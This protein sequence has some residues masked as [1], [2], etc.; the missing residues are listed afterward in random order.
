MSC[1]K[2]EQSTRLRFTISS[3]FPIFENPGHVQGDYGLSDRGGG[4]AD[5]KPSWHNDPAI[6]LKNSIDSGRYGLRQWKALER[7]SRLFSKAL[8][9]SIL[10]W[11]AVMV[12]GLAGEIRAGVVYH[13]DN[14]G[15]DAASG[16]ETAP[17]RTIAEALVR[18]QPGDQIVLRQ[19]VYREVLVAN[20][21]GTENAPIIIANYP[22][23]RA[24]VSALNEVNGEGVKADTGAGIYRISR[25]DN[26]LAGFGPS[27]DGFYQVFIDG[28]MAQEARHPNKQSGD[29]LSAD[30]AALTMDNQY[31]FTGLDTS[32]FSESD[33]VGARFLGNVGQGWAWQTSVV[34]SRS[35]QR[36]Q[37]RPEKSSQ[38]WW[39]NIDVKK[40]SDA[41][42]GYLVGREAFL[43]ADGE[44][45][46][47]EK[48]LYIKVSGGVL[49]ALG[50][51][52]AK[53]RNWCVQIQG[54]N[55]ITLKGLVFVGGALELD[56][57]GLLME[58]CEASHLSHFQTMA[59]GWGAAV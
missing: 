30:A 58:N 5:A 53:A 19:G 57:T 56:G 34:L 3:S 25:P 31:G 45:A 26:L 43:D 21:S 17:L 14:G 38:W 11:C 52:Q 2:P 55:Y 16:A 47:D 24:V 36:I 41:G 32:G 13:V 35:G 27:G 12:L 29:L 10:G 42:V 48:N 54:K 44:W 15:S 40:D 6:R 8:T 4:P 23:E 7:Q 1:L 9:R 49:P 22:G 18:A 51:V 33:L 39:P 59:T 46:A 50:Q 20:R 28:Q 37:L